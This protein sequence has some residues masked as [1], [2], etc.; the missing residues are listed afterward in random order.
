VETAHFLYRFIWLV[1]KG[2]HAESLLTVAKLE[3]EI[4]ALKS[5]SRQH[6]AAKAKVAIVA[7]FYNEGLQ[8]QFSAPRSTADFTH[9]DEWLARLDTWTKQAF[10]FLQT[11]SMQAAT[12][13]RDTSGMLAMDYVGIH[14][15]VH[16][17]YGILERRIAN[18]T[19]II[20]QQQTY[21]P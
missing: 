21:L 13:F 5:E 16:P 15:T 8:L 9:V 17:Q 3:H 14:V 19:A 4:E 12:K 18:I 10:A 11:C 6:A 7:S 1:P 20:E 2:M